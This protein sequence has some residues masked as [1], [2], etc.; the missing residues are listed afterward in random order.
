MALWLAL[1]ILVG[2]AFL[3]I[4]VCRIVFF[5]K[6]KVMAKNA[7]GKL[8][9]ARVFGFFHPY[10]NSGGGGERVL[11]CAIR[12][13]EELHSTG[14]VP[15]HVIVYTGDVGIP[16][17]DILKRAK[18]RFGVDLTGKMEIEFLYLQQRDLLEADR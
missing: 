8:V 5:K 18:D 17:A 4:V 6:K 15:I 9:P 12:A 11:W 13:L 14:T 10:C 1:P 16:A 3:A 2:V 7:K